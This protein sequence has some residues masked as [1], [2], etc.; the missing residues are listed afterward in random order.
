METILT[1]YLEKDEVQEC[2]QQ[3]VVGGISTETELTAEFETIT[4]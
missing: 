4:V 2:L 3:L 1:Q